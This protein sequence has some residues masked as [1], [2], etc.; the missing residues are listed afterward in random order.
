MIFIIIII[1]YIKKNDLISA[2]SLSFSL[3]MFRAPS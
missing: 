2:H 3:S 1:F